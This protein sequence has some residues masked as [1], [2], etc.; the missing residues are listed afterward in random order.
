MQVLPP[1]PQRQSTASPAPAAAAAPAFQPMRAAKKNAALAAA[2][3]EEDEED[4]PKRRLIPLQYTPAEVAAAR[5]RFHYPYTGFRFSSSR[6]HLRDD[7]VLTKVVL[8]VPLHS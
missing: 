8:A 2:F 3:G 5:V 6:C 1:P 7:C 4:K